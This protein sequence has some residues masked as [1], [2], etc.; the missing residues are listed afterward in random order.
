MTSTTAF[1]LANDQALARI[2]AL[3]LDALDP[4]TEVLELLKREDEDLIE[5]HLNQVGYVME[6]AITLLPFGHFAQMS[7]LH[8]QK[9]LEEY[10]KEL[11]T[12]SSQG[13]ESEFLKATPE[14]FGLKFPWD[15][16]QHLEQLTVPQKAKAPSKNNTS[17]S[18]GF[19][20]PPSTN[21]VIDITTLQGNDLTSGSATL[22]LVP[23][24]NG[25]MRPVYQP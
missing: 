18:S 5:D 4:L 10:N 13:R 6:F 2:K 7:Q 23:K 14:L 15:T 17:S 12:F 20:K 19:Q 25:Q 3:N 11:L 24:K 22:F 8:S 1:S 9:V 16:A 21:Q